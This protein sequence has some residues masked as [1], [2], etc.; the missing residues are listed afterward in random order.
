MHR[1]VDNDSQVRKECHSHG[2]TPFVSL[3]WGF[4]VV[5]IQRESLLS[6]TF[7]RVS[8][9]VGGGLQQWYRRGLQ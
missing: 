7:L 9:A 8:F 5:N 6:T 3:I 4:R 2:H 1:Y